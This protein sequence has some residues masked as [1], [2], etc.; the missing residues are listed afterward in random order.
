MGYWRYADAFSYNAAGAVTSMQLGN[1]RWESTVFNNRLQPTEIKLGTTQGTSN[2]LSLVFSYGTTNNNGNIL[3]QTIAV[4]DSQCSGPYCLIDTFTAV[5]TYTYDSLNRLK[6][7]VET[8]DQTGTWSQ[9]FNY[10]RYGNRKFDEANTS[11]PASFANP[12]VT[13]PSISANNNRIT[14]NGWSYDAAGNTLTDAGGLQFTYDGENKQVK[15]KNSSNV[16]VGEYFY[17][18]DGKRVKKIAGNEITVFVYDAAGK[19]IAE[20]SNVVASVEDAKVAYLTNDHLGSPRINTDRDGNVTSR[21]DY[22]PFGEEI[23]TTQRTGHSD[24]TPDSIRKQF[25][26]YERDTETDLDFAQARYF[27]PNVGRF[28]SPDDFLN[29]TKVNDPRSWNLFCYVRNLPLRFTDQMGKEIRDTNLTD[30]QRQKIIEEQKKKTGFKSITFKDGKL[31]VDTS[32]GYE[33]GSAAARKQLLD[34]ANSTTKVFNLV[35]VNDENQNTQGQSSDTIGFAK[36]VTGK[37]V[38]GVQNYNLFID[39]KDFDALGGDSSAMEAFSLGHAMLHEITHKIYGNVSDDGGDNRD[40]P[41]ANEFLYGNVI[42]EQLGLPIRMHYISRE[43]VSDP[44]NQYMTFKAAD[45][46]HKIL[47]WKKSVVKGLD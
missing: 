10:D 32:K 31:S 17:D 11:M 1:G 2:Y 9:T 18:G 26:G 35:G 7:A 22:H 29:D 14:S 6:S 3:S 15:V 12:P 40:R 37:D 5:Q 34:A 16:T 8:V 24:Y 36:T 13:N 28:S 41:G 19:Q 25:T 27:R 46:S 38:D 23:V 39:F 47:T 44:D 33:K 45:G 4:P 30:E 43:G 20:Y 42:R 21:H